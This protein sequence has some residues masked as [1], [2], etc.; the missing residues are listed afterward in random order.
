MRLIRVLG[1]LLCLVTLACVDM[2]A[3]MALA[4]A[5]QGEYHM[6]VNVN[7]NNGSHLTVTFPTDAL[8]ELKL[9]DEGR[10]NFARSVARFAV[11]HYQGEPLSD[12]RIAFQTVSNTGPITVTRTDAPFTF[13]ASE[14]K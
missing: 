5:I 6:P 3:I 7:V 2:K 1:G 10:A 12:V 11:S 8:A 14:L 13:T 9:S 4:E